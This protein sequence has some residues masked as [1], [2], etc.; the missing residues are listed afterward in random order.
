MCRLTNVVID[1]GRIRSIVAASSRVPKNARL[2]D[3]K[4]KFLIPGL[5]DAHVHLTKTGALSL[6]LFVANGVTGV[7]DM[8]SDL[9]EVAAWRAQIDRGERIGPRIKTSGQI[10]ES[11]A[12][13]ERMKREGTVE[14]VD[15]IRLG[16]ATPDEARAA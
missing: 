13:V 6:P 1:A 5:W 16:I 11:S 7:R 3:G 9:A 2:I 15:R 10:L 14:P 8:G 12:N 4:K